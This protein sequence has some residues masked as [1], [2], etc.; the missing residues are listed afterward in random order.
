MLLRREVL[1][2]V[3]ATTTTAT[4]AAAAPPVVR[5]GAASPDSL[6]MPLR[7]DRRG[8]SYVVDFAIEEKGYSGILDTASPFLTVSGNCGELDPAWGCLDLDSEARRDARVFSPTFETYGLQDDGV[9]DWQRSRELVLPGVGGSE[10]R[11]SGVVYGASEGVAST[12]GGSAPAPMF[13][14]VRDVAEGIRPS[15]LSQTD[16]GSF[17]VDFANSLLRLSRE[18][19]ARFPYGFPRVSSLPPSLSLSLSR[20]ER[21]ESGRGR[22]DSGSF[23]SLSPAPGPARAP[24]A[25]AGRPRSR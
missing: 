13:G 5:Q 12:R 20:C 1:Q 23:P 2:G 22:A 11:L 15:L 8:R 19:R 17:E 14:L 9:T 10:A 3:L 4:A 21:A 7:F 24:R 6:T 18:V 16:F 25:R